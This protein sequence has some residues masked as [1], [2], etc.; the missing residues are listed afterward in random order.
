[1][2][3]QCTHLESLFSKYTKYLLTILQ[4]IILSQRFKKVST[5]LKRVLKNMSKWFDSNLHINLTKYIT[6]YQEHTYNDKNKERY[7]LTNQGVKKT[8]DQYYITYQKS[9]LSNTVT[10]SDIYDNHSY[11]S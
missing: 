11:I 1:M 5:T 9:I 4:Q 8:N 2:E 3:D 7:K 10:E 6:D